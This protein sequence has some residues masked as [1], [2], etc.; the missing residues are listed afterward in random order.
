MGNL[1]QSGQDERISSTPIPQDKGGEK[2]S[3]TAV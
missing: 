2:E 1:L 3:H